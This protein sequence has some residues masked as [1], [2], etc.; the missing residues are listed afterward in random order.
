MEK[1]RELTPEERKQ[2]DKMVLGSKQINLQDILNSVPKVSDPLTDKIQF[3]FEN[4][5]KI[6]Y[7]QIFIQIIIIKTQYR[8]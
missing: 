1:M 6:Q 2:Y 3:P 7:T 5:S 4:D 8:E